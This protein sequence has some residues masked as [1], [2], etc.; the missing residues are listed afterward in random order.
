MRRYPRENPLALYTGRT[1]LGVY[2]LGNAEVAC[3]GWLILLTTFEECS[4]FYGDELGVRVG[5]LFG[6]FV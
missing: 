6:L 2:D 1:V 3:K 4:C 5:R